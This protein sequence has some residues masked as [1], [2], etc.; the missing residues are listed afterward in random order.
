[1]E[2]YSCPYGENKA[3]PSLFYLIYG[4]VDVFS[5]FLFVLHVSEAYTSTE[6]MLDWY[7]FSFVLVWRV[8]I[9]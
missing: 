2:G 3:K 6:S 1:M 5:V 4:V 9:L 8:V 7:I